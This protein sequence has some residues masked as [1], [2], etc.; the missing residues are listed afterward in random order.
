MSDAARTAAPP[1]AFLEACAAHG[2]ELSAAQL[3][4][5]QRYL[6]RLLA[7][8]QQLN[9]TAVR[10]ADTAWMRHIFDSIWVGITLKRDP[11]QQ[12]VD[13]GSGGGLPGIPLAILFPEIRW[14]L[15]DSVGKKVRFLEETAA[16][17]GLENVRARCVRAEVL[18]REAEVRAQVHVVTAR[19]VAR[20]PVLLEYAVPLLRDKG[21]FYAM[22]GEKAL[23]E[24]A[25]AGRA[26]ERLGVRLLRKTPTPEGGVLLVF[27]K[28][29]PTPG[30]YPRP[31]GVPAK[32][33]I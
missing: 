33:P 15:V 9:L 32:E 26:M 11:G 10:D 20:L 8:N 25:E 16:E 2:L 4:L 19:A 6:D 14:T 23:E 1:P 27:K 29:G 31:V 17:L 22:K 13:L 24:L 28:H 21:L 7:V 3:Q 5:L 12:A 18:G 30:K